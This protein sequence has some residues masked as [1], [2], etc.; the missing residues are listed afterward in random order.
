MA[1]TKGIEA[2]QYSFTYSDTTSFTIG[3]LPPGAYITDIKVLKTTSFEDGVLDVGDG[4]TANKYAD[5]VALNGTGAASVTSTAYWGAVASTAD[6]T[7]IKGIVVATGTG[8]SQGAAKVVV[9][10]AFNE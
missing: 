10:Y 8:L 1:R 6:Q 9:E 2:L 3:W 5:D 7:E 4:T